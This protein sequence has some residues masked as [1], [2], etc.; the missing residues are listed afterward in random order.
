MAHNSDYSHNDYA[1]IVKQLDRD[2]IQDDSSIGRIVTALIASFALLSFVFILWYAYNEG[3]RQG[4]ANLEQQNAL[5]TNTAAAAAN[6]FVEKTGNSQNL[7]ASTAPLLEKNVAADVGQLRPSYGNDFTQNVSA[8]TEDGNFIPRDPTQPIPL[9]SPE[10]Y[11]KESSIPTPPTFTN[12]PERQSTLSASRNT[13]TVEDVSVASIGNNADS[14]E[15]QNTRKTTQTSAKK[16]AGANPALLQTK[17][18]QNPVPAAPV[19]ALADDYGYVSGE[20]FADQWRIQL[21]SLRSIDAT[22]AMW[23]DKK[24]QHPSIL[25][26]FRLQIEKV[27]ITGKG[28]FYRL[29]F[30][31]FLSRAEATKTCDNLKQQKVDCFIV[32]PS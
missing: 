12:E 32:R 15:T 29:R 16:Q 14:L 30:G 27:A 23:Q 4:L 24:Q 9:S 22:N 21:A 31:P 28:D 18:T 1:S 17:E 3:K 11:K 20:D 7:S 25:S 6:N 2:E 5:S 8:N 26:G 13:E 19:A 10:Q